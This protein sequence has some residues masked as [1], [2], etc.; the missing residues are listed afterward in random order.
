MFF[1][2]LTLY[3]FH[4]RI[5]LVEL[6]ETFKWSI[7]NFV[8][9]KLHTPF[10]PIYFLLSPSCCNG[11]KAHSFEPNPIPPQKPVSVI[12]HFLNL[13]FNFSLSMGFSF[14]F[15]DGVVWSL[16]ISRHHS[17]SEGHIGLLLLS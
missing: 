12:F 1:K 17:L 8:F 4:C 15:E 6:T 10:I 13:L 5:C 2:L 14:L 11:R 7:F 3:S 16:D 9:T